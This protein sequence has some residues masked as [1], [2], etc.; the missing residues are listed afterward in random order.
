MENSKVS[1]AQE[2]MGKDNSIYPGV[3]LT[4]LRVIFISL[5]GV[6]TEFKNSIQMGITYP[7]L[8]AGR[9]LF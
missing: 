5:I 8:G 1:G 6:T 7:L 4:T 9:S 2:V 3:Y